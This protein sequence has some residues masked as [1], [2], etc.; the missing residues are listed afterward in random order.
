MG[1]AGVPFELSSHANMY[2]F[3]RYLSGTS[4][5]ARGGKGAKKE[6]KRMVMG[7]FLPS[8]LLKVGYCGRR[9]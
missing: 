1:G 7:K 2:F 6:M 5:I 4:V 9:N 8:H 3:L